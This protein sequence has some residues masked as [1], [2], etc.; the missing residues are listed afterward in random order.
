VFEAADCRILVRGDV[1]NDLIDIKVCGTEG[2][3]RSALQII[4]DDMERVH[5]TYKE[6]SVK[7]RVPLPDKEEVD[8]SYEHLL[9]LETDEGSAHSYRPSEANRKYTVGELLDNIPREP[10]QRVSER[11]QPST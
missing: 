11:E 5:R 9:K 7:R 6:L 8:E 4:L 2:L 10:L 1:D 3:Q